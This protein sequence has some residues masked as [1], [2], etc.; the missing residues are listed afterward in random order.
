M[1]QSRGRQILVTP[2]PDLCDAPHY[3]ET[4]F[5]RVLGSAV[6]CAGQ[7]RGAR[8]P[9]PPI[10]DIGCR[11]FQVVLDQ[12]AAR[13]P[14]TLGPRNLATPMLAGN[15]PQYPETRLVRGLGSTVACA[16][17]MRGSQGLCTPGLR[18][19][20]L[21]TSSGGM[22][23]CVSLGGECP[24]CTSL[25]RGCC[26]LLF[27]ACDPVALSLSLQCIRVSSFDL[28]I[29]T[30]SLHV[31]FSLAFAS[32]SARPTHSSALSRSGSAHISPPAHKNA[33][34]TKAQECGPSA[35]AQQRPWI[36]GIPRALRHRPCF[37]RSAVGRAPARLCCIQYHGSAFRAR[38]G[39]S[40]AAA[41]EQYAGGCLEWRNTTCICWPWRSRARHTLLAGQGSASAMCL[42]LD[43][44]LFG[45]W[46]TQEIVGVRRAPAVT[47]SFAWVG[48][49]AGKRGIFAGKWLDVEVRVRA[50]I[51]MLAPRRVTRPGPCR[52]AGGSLGLI[53][54]QSQGSAVSCCSWLD[55]PLL[56]AG[57]GGGGTQGNGG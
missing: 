46:W 41:D 3:S 49:A 43:F 55:S 56:E 38:E 7:V 39:C 6:A 42:E 29:Q 19:L 24:S 53:D 26:C 21:S 50:R 48:D 30:L 8:V 54:D 34:K 25:G 45:G 2:H 35:G 15:A 51:L 40:E 27:L 33:V 18:T 31:S 23:K 5:V 4:R 13:Q 14:Q 10:C 52:H 16:G 22:R 17:Q 37:P 9:P 20:Q 12:T 57:G 47:S 1:S 44:A 11:A 36:G 28:C 32:K